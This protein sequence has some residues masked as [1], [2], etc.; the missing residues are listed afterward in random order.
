MKKTILFLTVV[1]LL[2]FP[3]LSEQQETK[4]KKADPK[5]NLSIV[6]ELIPVPDNMKTGFDSISGK[7]AVIYLD[8]LSSDLLEGRDT[9]SMGY[10]IAAEYA[11]SMFKLWGIKPAGDMKRPSGRSSFGAPAAQAKKSRSYFQ[12]VPLREVLSTEST[13]Q[14]SWQKGSQKKSRTFSSEVDYSYNA[15]GSQSLTAPVVFVGYGIQEP[16]LKMDEYKGVDVKGKIVLMLSETPGKDDK[17]SPFNKGDLKE[18]YYP[19][20][21]MR[22]STSPKIQLARKLGA[23]AVALIENSPQKTGDVFRGMLASR[24]VNDERPIIP[25]KRRRMSLIQ[26]KGLSMPWNSV[27]TVRISREM[28]D[29]ILGYV[30]QKSMLLPGVSMTVKS[31]AETKLVS[32]SNVLGYIEGSDP[33]L[34]NEV[35][36]IGAHLDHLGMRGKYIYNGADDN[37]SGSVGVME[38][39]EAFMKNPV[40]PKRSIVFA[41]WTG[42]EKGLLGSRYYVSNPF[43]PMKK[44]VLNLNLDMIS[45]QWSQE[46]LTRMSRLMGMGISKEMMKE[47]DIKKFM[48]LSFAADTSDLKDVLKAN[49]QYVGMHL[50]LRPSK[51]GMGGSDHAP[52]AMSKIPWV[53]FFAAMTEDYHQPTDSVEKVCPELMEKI[54]RLAYLTAYII[55]DK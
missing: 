1:C 32:S 35:V 53:F 18:K 2:S 37:G 25:G 45:R 36:V 40:K 19:A 52:F 21:R 12:V 29:A 16:S 51:S 30:G 24:E 54:M 23:V 31:K 15:S 6:T 7:E 8:F 42:E 55:A 49:N 27:P 11:A 10:D 33:E 47:I 14:V 4:D 3:L 5:D 50:V 17:D 9:A 20:R 39:A 46:R 43:F 34:K 41:L 26:G 13:I 44:T 22:R 28:A 38:I 48:S